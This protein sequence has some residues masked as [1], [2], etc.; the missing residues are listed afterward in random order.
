MTDKAFTNSSLEIELKLKNGPGSRE[1]PHSG[2]GQGNSNEDDSDSDSESI[3]ESDKNNEFEKDVRIL[4]DY[5]LISFDTNQTFE[6]H[7]LMQL[8]TPK[9]AKVNKQLE[10]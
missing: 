8:A 7:S 10:V 6:M 1:E 5:S 4:R 2:D 3:S 9:W